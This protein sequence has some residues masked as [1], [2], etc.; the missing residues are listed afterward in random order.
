MTIVISSVQKNGL[1]FGCL[2]V[3]LPSVFQEFLALPGVHDQPRNVKRTGHPRKQKPD[4][5][6]SLLIVRAR[7]VFRLASDVL[8]QKV[9]KRTA[10]L[11]GTPSNFRGQSRDRTAP[12]GVVTMLKAQITVDEGL[13]L[14]AFRSMLDSTVRV[15]C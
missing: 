4:L 8:D 3:K 2:E 15:M 11:G 1:L 7:H 14:T 9:E 10:Y 12:R 6:I 13:Q 5:A